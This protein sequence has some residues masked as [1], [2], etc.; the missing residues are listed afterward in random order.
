[1]TDVHAP[2]PVL[3]A[4][5]FSPS[6]ATEP[7][8]GGLINKTY[9]VEEGGRRTV[10]QRLHT[11]FKPTV[12]LDIDVITAHLERKGMNTPR[13][14]KTTSA[15]LWFTDGDGACWRMLTWL[16]GRTVHV[17][18]R[19]ETAR[20]AGALVARFHNA[21]AD[22]NHTFNFSRPGAHDTPA[23]L[24]RLK[25]ALAEHTSHANHAAVSL[26]GEAI[27]KHW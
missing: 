15:E 16:P 7:L 5:G 4:F 21:V 1:M 18:E 8:E 25:R 23:H 27:V 6:A 9:L 2:A 14:V 10:L 19:P 22:L 3:S 11:I 13:L 20:A 12:H 24:D 26:V 17:V